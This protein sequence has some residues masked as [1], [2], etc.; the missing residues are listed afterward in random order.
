MKTKI[1][2]LTLN[3]LLGSAGGFSFFAFAEP[4]AA[5]VVD[6]GNAVCPVSGD[7]ISGK[8]FVE[9]Q[10]KRYGLCCAHCEKEFKKDPEKYTASLAESPA[11]A[12][13]T[14]AHSHEGHS[15]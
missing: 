3:L 6:V 4:A 10:G 11:E 13:G 7:K 8:H 12:P 15:H 9:Y 1:L 5:A 14:G 2:V